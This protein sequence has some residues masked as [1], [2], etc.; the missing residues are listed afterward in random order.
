MQPPSLVLC[1]LFAATVSAPAT[2][3]T[4]SVA[5]QVAAAVLPLP[6]A[7]RA[8]AAVMRRY[9]DGRL[10][11]LRAGRNPMICYA[12]A[13]GDTLFDVRCYHRD[14][15]PLMRFVQSQYRAGVPDSL[16]DSAIARAVKAGGIRLPATPTAGYRM[17]G[18]ISGFDAATTTAGAAIDRWQSVHI[19]YA[20]AESAGLSAMEAGTE[21][22][23]MSAGTW[24]AHVMIMDRPL[25]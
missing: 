1:A 23:L 9:P 22:Y 4:A 12:D 11:T 14:F 20:T 25:R 21:P 24:W 18:P 2:A 3:Q 15:V 19:P 10:D 13:P 17:L 8:D 16:I 7:L 6:L 5:S